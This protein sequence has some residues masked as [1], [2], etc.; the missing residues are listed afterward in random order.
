MTDLK[1][2]GQTTVYTAGM[3]STPTPGD[4]LPGTPFPWLDITDATLTLPFFQPAEEILL[5]GYKIFQY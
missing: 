3:W 5:S 4:N 1:K 2:R